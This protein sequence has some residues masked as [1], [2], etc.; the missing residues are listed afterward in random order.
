MHQ[1]LAAFYE[2]P[3]VPNSFGGVEV[4]YRSV[5]GKYSKKDVKHW[6]SQKDTYTLYKPVRHK[7]Q[8]NRVLVSDV[9]RQFQ[10]DLVD[11]QSLAEFNKV[12]K[13]LLTCIDLFSKFAWEVP[14]KDKFGKSV[15]SGLEIIFKERKPKV[16]QTDAAGD[17]NISL[18]VK[19]TIDVGCYETMLD[20]ISAVQF[21]L[22]KN[23]NRFTIIYNKATKRV[24]INAVLGS[25]LHLENLGELLGFKRNAIMIGQIGSGLTHYKGINF[26]KGYGIGGIFL[27]LF[28]AA[29]PFFSKM[30]SCRNKKQ[31]K[32]KK[33]AQKTIDR[34]QSMVGKGQYKRKRKKQKKFISSKARKELKQLF[35][36]GNGNNFILF[37]TLFDNA[38]VEFHISGSAEDYIY[39]SQTQLY[40]KAKIV[41]VDN[42]PI[43]KDDTIGPVNLFLYSLFS[44]VDVSLNDRV[45]SNSS[46]TYP[47]RSYIETLLNHGYDSK[48]SQLT[49][50]LFYKDSDD[51]LKK[52]TE[53]FKKSATVD[54]IGCIY[55][56]IYFIKIVFYSI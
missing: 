43:T 8:R 3:E 15:K 7:F 51:G 25:S 2:N 1:D 5:K 56:R 42:T 11:M 52:R 49:A 44:Q 55:I 9:D 37:L 46:N 20:I 4:L 17:G 39:F 53:F 32:W 31:R 27:C 38:P 54:M 30:R 33:L 24:K 36:M 23:P 35:K 21:A 41:K 10:T 45:V 13:Y 14:L 16:W 47:Y 34:V 6:L 29:L 12:Y 50:E 48:T 18:T 28:R 26:Q 22:P 40:V 19:R